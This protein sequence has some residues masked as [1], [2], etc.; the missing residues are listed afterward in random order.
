[1][2][3]S[4]LTREWRRERKRENNPATP[5]D[6]FNGASTSQSLVR[7]G[8]GVWTCRRWTGRFV[9]TGFFFSPAG[10]VPCRACASSA[11][12]AGGSALTTHRG[13]VSPTALP[14]FSVL[15]RLCSPPPV[16]RL[17]PAELLHRLLENEGD[18]VWRL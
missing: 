3:I 8:G 6:I 4:V 16:C 15:C 2:C 12:L 14:V 11:G 17:H 9:G 7:P 13:T 10:S 5:T 1:M 18:A